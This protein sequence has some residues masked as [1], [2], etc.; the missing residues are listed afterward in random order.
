MANNIINVMVTL[1]ANQFIFIIIT[2]SYTGGSSGAIRI[3]INS[4]YKHSYHMD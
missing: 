4:F 1:A 3:K 2:Y